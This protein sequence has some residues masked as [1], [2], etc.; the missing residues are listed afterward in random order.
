MSHEEKKTKVY[1]AVPL[2]PRLAGDPWAWFPEDY[3]LVAEVDTDD[4]DEAYYLTNDLGKDWWLN[5]G[6]T[7]HLV[8]CRSTSVGDVLVRP[9]GKV[10]TVSRL[11]YR[12]LW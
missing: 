4:V 3:Q 12:R 8:P 2:G 6:V 5:E 7:A 9:D 1:H 10:F 11:G